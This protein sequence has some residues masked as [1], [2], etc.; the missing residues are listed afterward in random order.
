MPL[1]QH[2]YVAQSRIPLE[3]HGSI[4]R[5]QLVR[6]EVF[7]VTR[8]YWERY[9][10]SDGDGGRATGGIELTV[11]FVETG[12]KTAE[13][14]ALDVARR[15]SVIV[16]F[17]YASRRAEPILRR[18]AQVGASGG[19]LAQHD[20]RYVD[21]DKFGTVPIESA[22]TDSVLGRIGAMGEGRRQTALMLG[23]RWHRQA[24]S[25]DDP[26]DS[27][28]AA[29]IGLEGLRMELAPMF[30]PTGPNAPCAVCENDGVA[31][32]AVGPAAVEHLFRVATPEVLA[33]RTV[34]DLQRLRN[35]IAHSNDPE[36]ELRSR[37]TRV[38][39]DCQLALG[40]ACLTVLGGAFGPS[41]RRWS[42]MLPRD[43]ESRPDYRY[44]VFCSQE[45]PGARPYQ[46][47]W[48]ELESKE[49]WVAEFRTDGSRKWR[50]QAPSV[51]ILDQ[52]RGPYIS[53]AIET[54]FL[55]LYERL[56][57]PVVELPVLS[58]DPIAAGTKSEPW[59]HEPLP[60]SWKRLIERAEGGDASSAS[61]P[62]S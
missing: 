60:E 31:E 7:D 4:P 54:R 27:F 50:M 35:D 29:W 5:T 25:I 19:L 18:I 21:D 40:V 22:V 42:A 20:Y 1:N 33:D 44:S 13:H 39:L 48:A 24:I 62:S 61:S 49:D 55:M 14:R 16:G 46:G 23:L 32:R 43:R 17:V 51:W 37:S 26:L 41:E 10:E 38:Y 28:L 8:G 11:Q 57:T 15:L 36:H 52:R 59:R 12:L 3:I 9:E 45:I 58:S 30:H 34:Q 53:E 2:I 47:E 6:A 56:G